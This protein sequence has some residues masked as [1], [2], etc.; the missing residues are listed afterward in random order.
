[1]LHRGAVE[2]RECSDRTFCLHRAFC[3]CR[4]SSD[5]EWSIF[6][7]ATKRPS[8]AEATKRKGP[9]CRP[10]GHSTISKEKK[11]RTFQH[12]ILHFAIHPN[13]KPSKALQASMLDQCLDR[14]LCRQA[15]SHLLLIGRRS[16]LRAATTIAP[17]SSTW[18]S[19]KIGSLR[20]GL[21]NALL[22]LVDNGRHKK[23]PSG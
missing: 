10:A 5:C 12:G 21:W 8:D 15:R 6:F 4:A 16:L 13:F 23:C 18:S 14:W 2:S 7:E 22:Q 9:H 19:G 11:G 20:L 3:A 1:M 17:S